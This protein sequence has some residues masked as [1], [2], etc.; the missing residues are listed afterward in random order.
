MRII[1]FILCLSWSFALQGQDHQCLQ[2]GHYQPE[3]E[4]NQL[5][6]LREKVNLTVVVHLIY[7]TELDSISDEQILSQIEVLNEDFNQLND[8]FDDTPE[9]FKEVA[10]N[11]DIKFCLATKDPDG[12]STTGITR[13]KTNID[14]IGLT[15][16][17]YQTNLGGI[18]AWDPE[19]YINIW[20]ADLGNSSI[21]GSG[22]FPGRQGAFHALCRRRARGSI[23]GGSGERWTH[24]H[25]GD[26]PAVQQDL[27]H[28]GVRLQYLVTRM[29]NHI[30]IMLRH[31][32][33]GVPVPAHLAVQLTSE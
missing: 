22:T 32:N 16:A 26:L 7:R 28:G 25:G 19:K 4:S 27:L 5:I 3:D 1:V 21:S 9:V 17:Y 24:R 11:A 30:S 14:D 18:D 10:A 31:H 33:G 2:T 23:G 8:N 15:E 12:H 6:Q 20:V 29:I 13:T